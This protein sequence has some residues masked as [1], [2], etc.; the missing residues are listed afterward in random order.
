MMATFRCHLRHPIKKFCLLVIKP[1]QYIGKSDIICLMTYELEQTEEFEDWLFTLSAKNEA[2]VRA[3]LARLSEGHL[4][5]FRIL[6]GGLTELKWKSGLRVY[7]IRISKNKV[8]I[9]LGGTKHGQKK[10]IEKARKMF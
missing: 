10:D 3:R 1:F 7:F 2:L 6:E 5:M 8:R 9:L 4:G